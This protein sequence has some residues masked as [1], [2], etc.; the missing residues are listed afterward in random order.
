VP[1]PPPPLHATPP[2][3][4][5]QRGMAPR[6]DPSLL[7]SPLLCPA[8]RHL[9]LDWPLRPPSLLSHRWPTG[10]YPPPSAA[11]ASAP[12]RRVASHSTGLTV[13]PAGRSPHRDFPRTTIVDH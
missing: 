1:G 4:P 9:T 3:C 6:R 2:P 5:A 7:R 12:A 13:N 8:S 11:T 10:R